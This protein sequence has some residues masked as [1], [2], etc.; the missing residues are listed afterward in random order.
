MGGGKLAKS[1]HITQRWLILVALVLAVSAAGCGSE[2]GEQEAGPQEL[3]VKAQ[4]AEVGKTLEAQDWS[5]G[6]INQPEQTKQVGSGAAAAMTD[7]AD[8]FGGRSGVREAEGVWLILT[9]EMVNATGDLAFIPKSL[10]MV[11]D[12]EGGQYPPAKAREAVAPL[13]N[14]DDRWESQEK[15]QL[16]QWVF[17]TDVA[18]QGPM[19][20]DVPEDAT[21]LELVME[22][23][24]ETI[25]LGF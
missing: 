4:N 2:E 21:G 7:E 24:D 10:L 5:I 17:D 1:R 20:F 12:A 16:I 6:L 8:G 13:I 18:L 25:D 15:N 19:V 3:V 22:G 11:T 14:A 23:T 9:V